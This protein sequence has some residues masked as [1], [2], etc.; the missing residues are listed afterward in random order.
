MEFK[1]I[2]Q[3]IDWKSLI[4][5]GG[6]F[7][8]TV[9][10]AVEYNLDILLVFSSIGLLYIGY[11]SQNRLQAVVLG[12]LGTVPLGLANLLFPSLVSPIS[13]NNMGI[14]I[15]ISFLAIGAFC[16]FAGFYFNIRRKKAIEAKI[17]Q[18][19][20][21]KGRKKKNKKNIRGRND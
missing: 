4:L 11:D 15:M 2:Y 10:T 13:G 12:T 18:E 20:I 5:G 14:L 21:G 7:A 8:F 6:V 16:G 1:D 9:I 17:K 19:S 3:K